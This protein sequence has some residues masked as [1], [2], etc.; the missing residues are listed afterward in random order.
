MTRPVLR[1]ATMDDAALASDVMTE[2]YP[3]L[4]QDPVMTAYY[5]AH[6]QEG[7]EVARFIGDLDGRPVAYLSWLHGPWEKLPERH[8]D[9]EVWV[10][11]DRL[12]PDL[13]TDLWRWIGAQAEATGALTLLAWAAEDEVEMLAALDRLD[14]ER[15]RYEK[16]WELDLK[17]HGQRLLAEAAETRKR[18]GAEGIRFATLA[19]W[20]HPEKLRRLHELNELTKQDIP[21]TVPILP[22]SFEDFESRALA[23]DRPHDRYWIAL[24]GDAPVALSFLR[25]PP[26]RGSVWT[27]YTCCHPDYRGRGLARAVKLQSL[28]QAIELGVPVV[29][30]DNDSQNAPMLHINERLGYRR[31]PGFVALLK[32]VSS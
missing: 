16:V 11:R 13:L 17:E 10:A 9:V 29:C 15:D 31:R 28:A 5:W 12:D 22:Q 23:P 18:P 8:C 24:H 27:G 25:F 4:P 1:P 6:V 30:T 2:S 7:H 3:A 14:Y 32:R 19:E 20:D 21:H 26:V